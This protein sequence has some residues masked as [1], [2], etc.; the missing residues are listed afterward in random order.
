[1]ARYFLLLLVNN[2]GSVCAPFHGGRAQT[3]VRATP[4]ELAEL[5]GGSVTL[6]TS[7]LGGRGRDW[8]CR[9]W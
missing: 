1:M 4:R 9:V 6:E 2:P 3:E 7:P 8:N 5:Y